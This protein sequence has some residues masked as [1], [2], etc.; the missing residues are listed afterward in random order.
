MK[1]IIIT[2]ALGALLIAGGAT[3]AMQTDKARGDANRDGTLTKAEVT[4]QADARFDR[5]DFDKDGKITKADHDANAKSRADARFAQLDTDKNGQISRAE[6]DA[7][8]DGRMGRHG[9]P[10]GMRGGK[11]HGDGMR[12][13]MGAKGDGTLT[14]DEFRARALAMFDRGDAN[15]DGQITRE[16]RDASR[17]AWKAKRGQ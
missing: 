10:D 1:K 2:S 8:R 5:L 12:G 17:A 7:M 13:A 16:E 4:A 15:K 14:K 11:H 3:A 9:K 6:F